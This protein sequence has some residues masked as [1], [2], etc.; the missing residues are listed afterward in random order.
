MIRS[1]TG[2]GDAAAQ[3]AGVH[4]SVELRSLNNKYLKC[5]IRLP[6][7]LQAIEAEI[8]AYLRRTLSRGSVVCTVRCSETTAD[9]ALEVNSEA[10]QRYIDTLGS[11][12]SPREGVALTLDLAALLQL[13]GVLQPPSDTERRL[14]NART[15]IMPLLEE[16][17]ARLIEM[18]KREGQSLIEDLMVHHALIA[19]RLQTVTE[20]APGVVVE[21]QN[22]L[23]QRMSTLFQTLDRTVEQG[24][25]IREVAIFAEKADIAEE[26]SR[27]TAH[28]EQFRQMI[29]ADD[30]RAIGRTLDFLSQEMLREANTIASKSPDAEIA[31]ATVDVKGSIDR[32]K[33][34]VQNAE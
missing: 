15:A 26:V 17:C 10:L 18:R 27:L 21:Y 4:Y 32:I 29:T 1:M 30:D 9:A 31:R 22:R 7:E 6:D 19:E 11:L 8:E 34:Q 33:E 3:H 28:L 5:N 16:A 14:E 25:I 24:D 20:R 13:P 2:F 12:E 23:I